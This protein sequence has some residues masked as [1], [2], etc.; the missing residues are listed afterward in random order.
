M[1]KVLILP[2]AKIDVKE[3][4]DWYN[5]RQEG[6]G[7][8]FTLHVR[9]KINLLR[10]GPFNYVTRYDD[11]KTAVLD[12][13]PFMIHYTVNNAEKLIIISAVLHTSRNPD[14]W[15]SKHESPDIID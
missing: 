3:A 10:K 1:Y 2:L 4:A 12:I 5:S 13:F 9:Q 14:A 7:R 6:L 15:K 11:V 8:K